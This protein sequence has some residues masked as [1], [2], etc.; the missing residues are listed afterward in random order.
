MRRVTVVGAVGFATAT[1]PTG[2]IVA[3]V[4]LGIG[5]CSSFMAPLAIYAR[6]FPPQRF[7]TLTGLQLGIGSIGTLLA[8]APLAFAAATIGWRGAFIAVAL[9]TLAAAALLVALVVTDRVGS[10]A[11]TGAHE[12]LRDSMTGVL[13]VLRTPSVG[14][15]FLIHLTSYATLRAGR[16]PVGRAVSHACLRLRTEGARRAAVRRGARPNSRLA[17]LGSDGSRVR[18][19]QGAGVAGR[20]TRP[21]SRSRCSPSSTRCATPLL[22]VW[23]AVFGFV[24]AYTPV[25]VAHGK[26]LFPPHLVGRGMT[27]AERRNDRRRVPGADA[28]RRRDRAVPGARRRLSARRLSGGVRPPGGVHA[29]R[30]RGLCA[31]RDPLCDA[32]SQHL[33]LM[34]TVDLH[35][36]EYAMASRICSRRTHCENLAQWH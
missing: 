21:A 19:P 3:R 6:R 26:S 25:L 18:E 7:A 2:L 9:I 17:G 29:G 14:R 15:L 1:S 4:L 28:E 27:R 12:S 10:G 34:R 13:E 20:R 22:I 35:D 32:A 33:T 16:R 30:V 5:S 31:A 24:C 11:R 36:R 23:F 8:T